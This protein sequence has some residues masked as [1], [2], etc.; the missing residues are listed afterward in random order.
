MLGPT[1]NQQENTQE[2]RTFLKSPRQQVG[3]KLNL[4]R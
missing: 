1:E 3:L 2:A 4:E